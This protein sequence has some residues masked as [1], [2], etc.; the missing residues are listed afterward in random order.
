VCSSDLQVSYKLNLKGPSVA[1]QTACSTS[2]VAVTLACQSLLSYQCDMALAGGVAISLPQRKGYLYQSGGIGSPDGH[3]RAFDADARGTVAGNGVGIVV[4]KRLSE[5]LADGDHIHAVIRGSAI[6]ND[7]AAKVGYTAP[8]V[9]G[10]AEVIALAQALAGVDPDT[11]TY[12]ET[13]GTG[14]PLGDPIEIAALHQ[15]FSAS[16]DRKN[17]C[18][19]GSLKTN[20]GHLDPAAG[21]S[22]LI[23]TVLAIEHGELPP[24]LHFNRPNPKI[25]FANSPF[26]VN[27]SLAEW[28]TNGYPR[29]AGVSSFGIGG[30]NAHVILEEAP[31]VERSDPSRPSQLLVLSGKT[32]SALEKLTDALADFLDRKSVV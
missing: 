3:C 12:I 20:V 22:G 18:A 19:I 16:T 17:F 8:G 30:T 32:S 13:H 5:A 9:N 10:Q 15:A 21:V 28:K 26:Y 4:L 11:I 7:G 1:V 24:S 25:D 6:N 2:L 23:K 14:T 27:T 29:R 31:Q